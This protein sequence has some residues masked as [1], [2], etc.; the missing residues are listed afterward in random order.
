MDNLDEFNYVNELFD[1]YGSL[2]TESQYQMLEQ[3]YIFNLSLSEIA[4]EFEISRTAVQDAVKK[5]IQKC[6]VYEEKL[7]LVEKKKT[8]NCLVD[9]LDKSNLEKIKEEIRKVINDGI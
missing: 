5:G 3:Y 4:E 6:K 9:E 2:L 8:L 1:T 7:K